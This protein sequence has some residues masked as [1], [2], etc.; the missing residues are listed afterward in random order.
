[1]LAEARGVIDTA[2]RYTVAGRA[3][4]RAYRQICAE[5]GIGHLINVMPESELYRFGNGGLLTSTKRVT[6]PV[7]LADHPL[8]LSY[9]VVESPVL[10]LL[11][12]RDV[13]EGLGLDIKG[14]SKTLEYDGRSQPLENSVAGHYCVTLSPERYAG[15]LKLE[16]SPD[17]PTSRLRPRPTSLVPRK[18]KSRLASTLEI[19]FSLCKNNI[20][21]Q[22]KPDRVPTA[23]VFDSDKRVVLQT[24]RDASWQDP[25]TRLG[26]SVTPQSEQPEAPTALQ[27]QQWRRMQKGTFHQLR[28]GVERARIVAHHCIHPSRVRSG[29]RMTRT[30]PVDPLSHSV[31]SRVKPLFVAW[32]ISMD[33]IVPAVFATG[34]ECVKWSADFGL[35]VTSRLLD[36]LVKALRAGR[37][38]RLWIKSGH[39]H[40]RSQEAHFPNHFQCF[41]AKTVTSTLVSA[42][43]I[44][45]FPWIQRGVDLQLQ[46]SHVAVDTSSRN[47]GISTIASA[48][49]HDSDGEEFSGRAVISST[50]TASASAR[51]SPKCDG[52]QKTAD[53]FPRLSISK[54][55]LKSRDRL[56]C[57]TKGAR[58]SCVRDCET[59]SGS[60]RASRCQCSFGSCGYQSTC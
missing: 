31:I 13:V 53:C 21:G 15:L 8:L 17:P 47:F 7:V 55:C 1:M 20:C 23:D 52:C 46:Q 38:V 41:D 9:S 50:T 30:A 2:A 59:F 34:A 14:S 42:P 32:T 18:C 58:N 19:C 28:A 33:S 44:S 12:G 29:L 43:A 48:P 11:I 45:E 16:N 25:L 39:G 56:S 6:V 51:G 54:L 4:D 37:S 5:R 26:L 40:S 36:S 22:L 49:N 24:A 10:S 35:S 60:R 57:A 27:D 3:W